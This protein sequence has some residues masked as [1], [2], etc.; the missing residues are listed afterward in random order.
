MVID[1]GGT[2]VY[3][4]F[5]INRRTDEVEYGRLGYSRN[6]A[7]DLTLGAILNDT[8]IGTTATD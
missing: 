5:T 7:M 6:E 2:P 8:A 3:I 4:A 1:V